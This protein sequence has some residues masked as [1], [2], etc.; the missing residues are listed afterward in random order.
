MANILQIKRGTTAKR[1]AYTPLLAELVLDTTTRELFIGDGSSA[2]GKPITP[3]WTNW[4]TTTVANVTTV[5]VGTTIGKADVYVEGSMQ[6]PGYHYTVAGSVIT[7][8]DTIETG[9]H[10]YVKVYA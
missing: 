4:Y 10:I 5:N 8:T 1:L 3:S 6:T 7:F 9:T 2:G